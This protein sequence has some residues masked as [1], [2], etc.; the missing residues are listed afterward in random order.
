[1][2]HRMAVVVAG[3]A[4]GGCGYVGDPLP[5]SLRIPVAIS[6]LAAVER[7]HSIIV[8]FTI[9]AVT[10]DALP[11]GRL[12]EV[13][14]RIGA[15]GLRPWNRETWHAAAAR[16]PV[17]EAV[18][19]R[20]V[21]LETEAAPW[22]GREVILG[23][24]VAGPSGRWS[25]WSNLVPVDVVEPAAAPQELTAQSA[26]DGVTLQ[27]RSPDDRPG[28]KFRVF[29]SGPGETAFSLAG[30][31]EE[32]AWTD[33]EARYGTTY[34]YRVQAVVPAGGR[35]AESEL[36]DP[37]AITPE[38]RFSPDVPAGLTAVAALGAIELAWDRVPEEGAAYRVYRSRDDGEMSRIA[39]G[40]QTP[41]YSDRDI[42]A[43]ARYAYAVSAVDA[44]DNESDKSAAVAVTA[45]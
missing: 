2:R 27:W 32:L 11:L 5:P 8:Q 9:P 7:G 15:E 13:E 24:R 28:R 40:L 25:E 17:P 23:A 20:P 3:L 30:Q 1:M 38:D 37:V 29:R 19:G 18:P 45:P 21:R 14:L 12:E 34:T 26:R 39:D 42:E 35:T 43:G 36:S 6:D 22:V 4:L 31:T 44:L 16:V 10:T 33:R 41:V